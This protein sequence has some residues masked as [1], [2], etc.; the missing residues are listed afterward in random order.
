MI[1]ELERDLELDRCGVPLL[2][3]EDYT[4]HGDDGLTV[5]IKRTVF[6]APHLNNRL[7]DYVRVRR[8]G[9]PTLIVTCDE[10][11]QVGRWSYNGAWDKDAYAIL[12]L[13]P[14]NLVCMD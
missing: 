1:I 7:Q 12:Q 2:P 13:P 5:H 4:R 6:L 3:G 10:L 9:Q 8:P 11:E 14:I